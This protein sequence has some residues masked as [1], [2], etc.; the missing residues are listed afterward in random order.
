[1]KG[2]RKPSM[3]ALNVIPSGIDSMS[4]NLRDL[5]VH[6]QELKLKNTAIPFDF[7]CPLDGE[8]KPYTGPIW[9]FW[10]L[11]VCHPGFLQVRDLSP[12]EEK[13]KKKRALC[14]RSLITNQPNRRMDFP[15][16]GGGPGRNR[17]DR[18]LGRRNMRCR[19]GMG[20]A[21]SEDRRKFPSTSHIAGLR[22]PTYAR[23]ETDEIRSRGRF[24]V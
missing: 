14:P 15:P 13:G 17:P 5:S 24:P 4:L 3:S 8:G 2:R 22:S 1:M 7:M 10:R 12:P 9:R 11:S 23:F 18:R 6:L 20:L 19:A 21:I 16:H